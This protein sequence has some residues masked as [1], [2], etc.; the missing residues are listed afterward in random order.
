MFEKIEELV[1]QIQQDTQTIKEKKSIL[2][3]MKM[4][5]V[6][7]IID[8]SIK[9]IEFDSISGIRKFSFNTEFHSILDFIN[10]CS[11]AIKVEE[12]KSGSKPFKCYM[13]EKE[14][15]YELWL[16]WNKEFCVTR[17]ANEYSP[18][19]GRFIETRE[20]EQYGRCAFDMYEVNFIWD[21]D[22]I[23]RS[24][25]NNLNKTATKTKV[26]REQLESQIRNSKL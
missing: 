14:G 15:I 7:Y 11:H 25:I 9:W 3:D 19:M 18:E 5:E 13:N 21:M 24:I 12:Y 22:C 16:L 8:T 10:L 2:L 17:V 20:V 4:K 23:V 6:M 1:S 26:I